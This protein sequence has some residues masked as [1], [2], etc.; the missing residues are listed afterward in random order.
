MDDMAWDTNSRLAKAD[1]Q[2]K[3]QQERK[4][5]GLGR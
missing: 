1:G 3:T 4:N 2:G 5:G